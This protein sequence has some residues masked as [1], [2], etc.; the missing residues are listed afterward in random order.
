MDSDID[1]TV[2]TKENSVLQGRVV[3][4]SYP[5]PP[6]SLDYRTAGYVTGVKDQGMRFL[7]DWKVYLKLMDSRGMKLGQKNFKVPKYSI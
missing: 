6:A 2:G 5:T 7:M 3:P 4:P 1:F